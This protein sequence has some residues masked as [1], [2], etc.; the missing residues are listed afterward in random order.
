MIPNQNPSSS[1]FDIEKSSL[2]P[3]PKLGI[4]TNPV[5]FS[6]L[7]IRRTD[8]KGG[9][10]KGRIDECGV[11]GAPAVVFPGS[12]CLNSIRSV[13][14]TRAA[15]QDAELVNRHEMPGSSLQPEMLD[16]AKPFIRGPS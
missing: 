5:H 14:F 3:F 6:A 11:E 1:Q 9:A 4:P 8:E 12:P 15:G 10:V 13:A 2:H 7:T 16:E